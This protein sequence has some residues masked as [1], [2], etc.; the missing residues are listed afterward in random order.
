MNRPSFSILTVLIL[1]CLSAQ[2]AWA[3][4][5][6][7]R[8]GIGT[9]WQR[10]RDTDENIRYAA[11]LSELSYR[12][13]ALEMTLDL[14][15]RWESEKWELDKE[16]WSRQGDLLRTVRTF[17]YSPTGSST[18]S[19]W[20][21]GLELLR[22]WTP[23][24]G[25]LIRDLSG[26]GE[27]DYALPGLRFLWSGER[28][29]IEAGMDRPVN[30][31]VQ[32]VAVSYKL[33]DQVLLSFEAASDPE[34][35]LSFTGVFE[36]GRPVA[37]DTESITGSAAGLEMLLLDGS[38]LDVRVGGHAGK[39]GDKGEGIGGDLA[40]SLDF[41]SYYRNQLQVKIASIQCRGGY[42]PA[43]FDGTYP[44]QRW[45]GNGQPL[46]VLYPMD[47]ATADRQMESV[48]ISY[49][50]GD[51]LSI[52]GGVERL[53][54]D[55]MSKARFDLALREESGRGLEASVWSR[56]DDADT[57]FFSSDANLYSRLNALYDLSPHFLLKVALEH[58]WA[59]DEELA[60]LVPLNSALIGV[61]YNIS[62]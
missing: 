51:L 34:A 21:A 2:A 54:D 57:R 40:L 31:T 3:D 24:S 39:L 8:T 61:M 16:I 44:V 49:E 29:R 46:L 32:A 52:R 47:G 38:M 26:A 27:I 15:L 14:P 60:G 37:D 22:S 50:L 25:Y 30:P 10:N 20:K 1:L 17:L 35:P 56:V 58:S 9:V 7:L 36:D 42:L 13:P 4:V 33:F 41:S 6:T 5:I 28:T 62:F 43:W 23:G 53:D 18:G 55:S 12:S 48:E 11:L 59:F 19:N 45:G